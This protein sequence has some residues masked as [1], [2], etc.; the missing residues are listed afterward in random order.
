MDGEDAEYCL[1]CQ[2]EGHLLSP[3][4]YRCRACG[5]RGHLARDCSL[6]GPA[7]TSGTVGTVCRVRGRGCQGYI[8]SWQK[9]TTLWIDP[10]QSIDINP[11]RLTTD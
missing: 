4:C 5:G 8:A 3:S 6:P 1:L 9:A 2:E 7:T 10:A 11:S